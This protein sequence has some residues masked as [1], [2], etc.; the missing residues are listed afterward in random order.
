MEHFL[1]QN[2]YKCWESKDD[3]VGNYRISTNKYQKRVD[4]TDMFAGSLLCLCND[5]LFINIEETSF[6][7]GK[8][9]YE[10]SMVHEN[11]FNEW[12][13]LKIYG[14]SS[15]QIQE[16]LSEYELKLKKMWDIFVSKEEAKLIAQ[17]LL[18]LAGE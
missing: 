18:E 2:G 14:L 3:Q 4:V 5:K 8:P 11:G 17:A 1:E 6:N 12:C 13:N 7:G 16:S 9:Y 10:I 15:R